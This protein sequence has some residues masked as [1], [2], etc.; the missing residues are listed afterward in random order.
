MIRILI[1]DD[2]PI[3]REGIK[4][5]ISETT[6][7]VIADEASDGQEA[8]K[9]VWKNNY[10]VAVLDIT[11]PHGNGM[12][13][14]GQIRKA[15]PKLPVLMLSMYPEDQ[16]AVRAL[17]AGAASYLTKQS[18]PEELIRAIRKI[19]QGGKYISPTLAERLA[20]ELSAKS[21]K[22]PHETLSDREYQVMLRIASGKTVSE[23]AEELSLSVK[24]ISTY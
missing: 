21:D 7:M 12:E 6:D 24:T 19:F 11:M 3:I 22:P 17:K 20:S 5:I 16:Y 23:I 13:I 10:D 15:R 8:L 18:I 2:Q 1:A 9:K 4:Q 14:L